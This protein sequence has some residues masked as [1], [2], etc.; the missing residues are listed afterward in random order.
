VIA[1]HHDLATVAEYFDR[2]FMINVGAVAEGPCGE[3]FTAEALA[4]T[5]G[6]R[7]A[8]THVDHAGP[9]RDAR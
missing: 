8:A 4:T 3:A 2:V 9:G 7:L 6:G 1:V 5:Y